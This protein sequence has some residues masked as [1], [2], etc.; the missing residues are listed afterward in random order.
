MPF[1]KFI[2]QTLLTGIKPEIGLDKQKQDQT[3][4]LVNQ[5]TIAKLIRKI[6][7]EQRQERRAARRERRAERK[8][9]AE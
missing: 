4:A 9:A 3:I 5:L 6:K 7:K 2:W 1:F 8:A